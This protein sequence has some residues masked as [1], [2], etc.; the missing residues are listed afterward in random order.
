MFGC[1]KIKIFNKNN[2]EKKSIYQKNNITEDGR[3]KILDMLTYNPMGTYGYKKAENQGTFE[4]DGKKIS[5]RNSFF[6]WGSVSHPFNKEGSYTTLAETEIAKNI[7]TENDSLTE[8]QADRILKVNNNLRINWGANKSETNGNNNGYDLSSYKVWFNISIGMVDWKEE[9][10][11]PLIDD[12]NNDIIN[13]DNE[14]KLFGSPIY[15]N[16]VKIIN[17]KIPDV[18]HYDE[19]KDENYR[20]GDK[21]YSVDYEK[22]VLKLSDD[23]RE[24]LQTKDRN[25]IKIT[26]IWNGARYIDELKNG[27]CGIYVNA[28][29]SVKTNSSSYGS[30]NYFGMGTFSYDMGKNWQ[31]YS[32]PWKGQPIENLDKNS[33]PVFG[34][35]MTAF[36]STNTEFEHY[37]PTFPYTFINP[38]NFAFAFSSN[39]ENSF[40]IKN[41][42]FLVPDIPP[43]TIQEI[44]IVSGEYEIKKQIEWQGVGE[45]N[46]EVYA[47]WKTYLDI[48]EGGGKTF[49][50]IRTY[51]NEKTKNAKDGWNENTNDGW[52]EMEYPEFGQTIF[53]EAKFSESWEKTED[54]LIE[55]SYRIYFN[56][57]SE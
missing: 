29:P 44:G 1:Y 34:K 38:T 13:A 23:L 12:E 43:F 9:I 15:P 53:S 25:E 47:E 31:G 14:I 41:L 46:G 21:Y 2:V 45:E 57:V 50:T 6:G 22:G 26:Y 28:Q 49:D 42:N 27:I 54:D 56:E 39:G 52:N 16:T 11:L 19:K 5:Y 3:K 33:S 10:E 35:N 20:G 37:F 36:Y 40:Y 17:T 7:L 24:E 48:N 30:Q 32:F 4:K 8:E 55:I 51:F 18:K